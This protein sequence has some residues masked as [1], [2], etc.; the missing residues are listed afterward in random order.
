MDQTHSKVRS[1]FVEFT[2]D[3][4][5]ANAGPGLRRQATAELL[6]PRSR[7]VSLSALTA[8]PVWSNHNRE[9]ERST[10]AS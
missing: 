2:G 4:C 6:I 10:C 8:Q 9:P 7:A 3:F 5:E 1:D